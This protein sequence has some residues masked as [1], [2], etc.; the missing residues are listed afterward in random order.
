MEESRNLSYLIRKLT[1][2]KIERLLMEDPWS[3]AMLAKL[4]RGIGKQPGEQPELFEI[5]LN[6]V[7]E[8]LYGKGD[9]VSKPVWAIYTALTLFALHQQ[10]NEQPMSNS[11][12]AEGKK[13]GNSL[14]TAVGYLVKKNDED[15]KSAVKRRFDAVI[16]ANE[17]TEFAYHARSLI[18]L[19]KAEKITLDYPHLAED[20]YW[21]QF[22]EV[23]NRIR[24]RWG[25]DFYRIAQRNDHKENGG[26]CN[27]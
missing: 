6:N 14:G 9:E 5:L 16:T 2:E 11:G 13:Q 25:E 17:F 3:R 21:Y 26:V 18:Q 12:N 7:P 24:M 20:F 8:D 15:R 10:G 1:E 22:D 4:R 19:L 27:E 23:R